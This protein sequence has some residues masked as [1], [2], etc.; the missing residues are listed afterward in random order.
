MEFKPEDIIAIVL[1]ALSFLA[2]YLGKVTWEQIL[3]IITIIIGFYFGVMFGYKR[4]TKAV[5]KAIKT[6]RKND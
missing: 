4:A 2:L 1:L 3:P 6:M 5:E